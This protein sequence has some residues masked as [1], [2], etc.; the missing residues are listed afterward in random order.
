ML[1]PRILLWRSYLPD[2]RTNEQGQIDVSQAMLPSTSV[3]T[4]T[5]SPNV[6]HPG[7]SSSRLCTYQWFA[8]GWGGRATQGN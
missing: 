8:P 2:H 7:G 3:T 1:L 6:Q 4:P 5:L